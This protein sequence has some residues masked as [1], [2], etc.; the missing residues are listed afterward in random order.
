LPDD[1][2]EII[3]IH[4][5]DYWRATKQPIKAIAAYQLHANSTLLRTL[6]SSLNG[7][8]A[9]LYQQKRYRDAA[10]C[11]QQLG[12][13]I[14][15]KALLG[16]ISYRKNMAKMKN[17][18]GFSLL[19]DFSHIDNSYSGTEAGFRAAMKK[20]DLLYLKNKSWAKQ[21]LEK[22]QEIADSSTDRVVQ[23]EA[24]FKQAL[25]HWQLGETGKSVELLQQF[26]REFLIGDVRI[27]AQALLIDILPGEI[28][29][30]VDRQEYVNALV[31]AK[32]NKNL[33]LNNWIN[34]KFLADIAEA[35]QRVGLFD[36]SQKLYL[37]LIEIMPIDQR[38]RFYLPMI[39]STFDHG[40]YSLVEDYS[41]QYFY[42]YPEG[43]NVG[44]V[45]AIRLQSLIADERLGEA[46]K[47]LPS[48]LPDNKELYGIAGTLYF[49]TSDYQNG[50]VVLK[51]LALLDTPLP[52]KEQFMM[53]ECLF[54][55][56]AL[57]E[58]ESI[59][60]TIPEEHA[61]YE[62]SLFRLAAI[63]RNKGNEQKAL[64]LFKKI[65]ET[66]KSPQWKKYAERELQF[67]TLSTR[68][69]RVDRKE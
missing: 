47:L 52:A 48:P 37:Y 58:A 13:V 25:L 55:T 12:S 46:L 29:R 27:S 32:K 5:A 33:F 31:L 3:Q 40:D 68:R 22:Y 23:E 59:F 30:L 2:Q 36:E 66:G 50:L 60:Q 1:L 35:Y 10:S 62:Q 24:F 16:L 21:A 39:R 69:Q 18:E 15:D 7:Y 34:S 20:N 14:S 53:A 4:Q 54:Q 26:L 49:R 17:Q 41:S 6:P 42:N 56:G 51:K 65:V 19:G 45:L 61:F 11:Y 38:E 67:A 43:E 64:S 44:E 63:E 57:A 8:C 28:K 9:S